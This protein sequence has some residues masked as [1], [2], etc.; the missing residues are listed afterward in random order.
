MRQSIKLGLLRVNSNLKYVLLL[1][2]V[3]T[4]FA[5]LLTG[6]IF[7]FLKESLQHNEL[8]VK[9]TEAFDYLWFLELNYTFSEI[10][11]TLPTILVMAG[12]IFALI[13]V[14][15][16]SGMYQ[17]LSGEAKKNH[18][19]D[20]FYGCVRYSYRFFKVFLI[21]VVCYVGLYF[22]NLIYLD[23]TE[24]LSIYSESQ[25]LII[26]INLLRYIT[27]IFIFG[28]LNLIFDYVRIRIVVHQNY[29]VLRDLWLSFKL[30]VKKF[31][32][33][34]ILFWFFTALGLLLYILHTQLDNYLNP[35]N[36]VSI[37]W[38]FIMHQIYIVIKIWMKL[39]CTSSQIEFFRYLSISSAKSIKVVQMEIPQQGEK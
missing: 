8:A 32:R 38:V 18:F 9:L 36:Y 39:F 26:L 4:V 27:I 16:L 12:I 23:Y 10:I 13:Q 30:I 31:W 35:T 5:I 15:L 17:I 20:F 22:V 6:P 24:I 14:F 1:W 11:R 19:I 7:I 33:V 34:S 3:N 2:G 37:F 25:L 21:S 28:T 29:N